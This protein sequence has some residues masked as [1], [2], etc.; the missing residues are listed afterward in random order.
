MS[1][2]EDGNYDLHRFDVG[3]FNSPLFDNRFDYIALFETDI[4]LVFAPKALKR[5]K[6]GLSLKDLKNNLLLSVP[7][8]CSHPDDW[9]CWLDA[10]GIERGLMTFGPVFDNYPLVRE[11]VLNNLGISVARAP[12]AHETLNEGAWSNLLTY[13]HQNLAA[14]I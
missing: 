13:Q 1:T 5:T 4:Y 14:G 6:W 7:S 8:T 3:I 12:F 10:A 9:N 2:F 11:A